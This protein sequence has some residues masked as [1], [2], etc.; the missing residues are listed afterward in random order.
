MIEIPVMFEVR[1]GG[2]MAL[3]PNLVNGL[4]VGSRYIAPRPFGPRI[5]GKDALEEAALRALERAGGTD[6]RFVDDFAAYSDMGG[7]VHCGTNAL[8]QPKTERA[9]QL[10]R[11]ESGT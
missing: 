4:T 5:N 3:W 9:M 11:L 6:V 7:E 8:R 10:V 1:R 2:G